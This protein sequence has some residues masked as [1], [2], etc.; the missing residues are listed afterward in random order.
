MEKI[1][2]NLKQ[3]KKKKKPT[4]RQTK[5]VTTWRY[6]ETTSNQQARARENMS[7]TAG[8]G[9]NTWKARGKHLTGDRRELIGQK[10][11]G[12]NTVSIANP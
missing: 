4:G 11:Q 8:A 5:H 9:K 1:N 10:R 7:Q 6:M 2:Q 3:I 12:T